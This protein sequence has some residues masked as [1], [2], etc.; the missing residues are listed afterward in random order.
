[1]E[2][3]WEEGA[4]YVKGLVVQVRQLDVGQQRTGHL[5]VEALQLQGGV[6]VLVHHPSHAPVIQRQAF[7]ELEVGIV[8]KGKA[9]ERGRA[10]GLFGVG[11][12]G[13]TSC[14]PNGRLAIGEEND[15]RNTMGRERCGGGWRVDQLGS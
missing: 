15:Q 10:Q 9:E 1:M 3:V 4:R 12:D 6:G 5:V 13:V 14:D 11:Q 8:P 7:Q 2:V